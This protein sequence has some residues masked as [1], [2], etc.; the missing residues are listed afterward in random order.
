MIFYQFIDLIFR[1]F[2]FNIYLFCPR[3]MFFSF[4]SVEPVSN[5]KHT[6]R[7]L[8]DDVKVVAAYYA[9]KGLRALKRLIQV[10]SLGP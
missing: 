3:R 4:G 2:L 1:V 7:H 6:R 8:S 10:P 9:L 5:K